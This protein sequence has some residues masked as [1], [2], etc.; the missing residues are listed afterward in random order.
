M[1]SSGAAGRFVHGRRDTHRSH[2]SCTRMV[3]M[4]KLILQV[5]RVLVAQHLRQNQRTTPLSL[6]LCHHR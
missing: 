2:A 4:T 1:M 6:P 3:P 5:Q